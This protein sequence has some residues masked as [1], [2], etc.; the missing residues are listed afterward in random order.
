[1]VGE[2]IE[3]YLIGPLT[4]DESRKALPEDKLIDYNISVRLGREVLGAHFVLATAD[5]VKAKQEQDPLGYEK[6]RRQVAE[7][8][9]TQQEQL[10]HP[11]LPAGYEP[12]RSVAETDAA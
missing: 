3:K 2:Q 12:L 4:N 9:R 5:E 1:M 10:I 6:L 8:L 7:Q 11:T